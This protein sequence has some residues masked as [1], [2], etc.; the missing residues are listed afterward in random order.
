M[1]IVEERRISIGISACVYGCKTRY[2]GKGIDVLGLFGRE[3]ES[4]VFTPVCP[5]VQSGM[6]IPRNPISLRGGCGSD[7]WKGEAKVKNRGGEDVTEAVKDGC[8]CCMNT[9]E[10]AKVD[11]FVFM[12]GSPSCGVYRTSLKGRR[13]GNPPGIF[14]ALLLEKRIFLIPAADLQSPIKR[15]DWIRRLFAFTW[16]KSVPIENK[17]DMYSMWHALKFICQEIDNEKSREIGRRIAALEKDLDIE[18]AEALR[19]EI[20]EMLRKPSTP[21]KIKQMLWKSYTYYKKNYKREI[22]SINE[23]KALRNMTEVVKELSTM[24]LAAFKEGFIFGASPVM[25]REGRRRK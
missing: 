17:K 7:V 11:A 6:G 20:L 18:Y 10:K 25:F 1:S 23:P 9:L 8:I 24:E 16:L 13:L 5:E 19:D 14:G 3:K 4:F 2:N 12:E 22:E 21:A 15:W